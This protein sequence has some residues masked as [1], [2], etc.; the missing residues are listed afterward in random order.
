MGQ[1][2]HLGMCEKRSFS[3]PTVD[4]LRGGLGVEEEGRRGCWRVLQFENG[5]HGG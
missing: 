1:R 4:L 3:G 5:C 2:Q